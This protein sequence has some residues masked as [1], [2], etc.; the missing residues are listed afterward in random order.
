M[1]ASGMYHFIMLCVAS[2]LVLLR[3]FA[4]S[5]PPAGSF[6]SSDAAPCACSELKATEAQL[7]ELN[8]EK[9]R[10][11]AEYDKM[12]AHGGRTL[13][14]RTRKSELEAR[15]ADIGKE[16]SSLRLQLKTSGFR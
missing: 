9:D 6:P 14:E 10:L 16:I 12:P 5:A 1:L 7:L 4:T 11:N 2:L 8:T 3:L 13:S 15:L